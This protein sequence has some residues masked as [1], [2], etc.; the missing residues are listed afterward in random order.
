MHELH[1]DMSDQHDAEAYV[2][3]YCL[4]LVEMLFL[5]NITW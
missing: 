4:A 3:I 5:P 2:K 1:T